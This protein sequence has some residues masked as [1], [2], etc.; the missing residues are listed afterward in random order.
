M[1]RDVKQW[2][3]RDDPTRITRWRCGQRLFDDR[4]CLAVFASKRERCCV[5][6][7]G[8]N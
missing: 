4:R 7:G 2:L 8:V 1:R 5:S 3:Y 6:Y